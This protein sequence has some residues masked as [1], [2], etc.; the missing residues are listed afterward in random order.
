M[1]H[2]RWMTA[3]LLMLLALPAFA[4]GLQDRLDALARRAQPA[5][6]GVTVLDLRSGQAWR[7][8]AGRAYP[9]MSVF[10]APLGAA[11]LARVDR[12]ELSLDQPVTLTRA[13][14][15]LGRSAIVDHF[16]GESMR[17]TV[18]ELLT[19]AVGDSDNTAADALLPLAGGPAGVTAYLRAHGIDGLRV[20]RGEGGIHRDVMGL[21]AHDQPPAH[22]SPAQADARIRR[23]YFAYMAGPRDTS[24]PDAAATFLRQLWQGRLLSP[25]STHWLLDTMTHTQPFRIEP[26]LPQGVRFAHKGGTS[27]TFEGTTA[28][29]NDIG[30]I[31]WPD[32]HAVVVAA[33]LTGSKASA[34]ERDALF[35]EL[36][37]A[38]AGQLG[39]E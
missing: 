19:A 23:G 10:K 25:T 7:V 31:A 27:A 36:G 5:K 6:L 21:D 35:A 26:G 34:K 33:F 17:F 16:R 29:F 11:V 8:G 13:D 30:V 2:R 12:G 24:T 37:R 20:D 38:V 32:G 28:A 18:R 1:R 39:Q 4:D 22:E 14:L 3:A 15:R 9:M